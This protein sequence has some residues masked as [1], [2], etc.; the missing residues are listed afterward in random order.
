MTQP[1]CMQWPSLNAWKWPSL[2]AWKRPGQCIE[3]AVS[4]CM[5]MAQSQHRVTTS[6]S[7]LY[8][9]MTS[10]WLVSTLCHSTIILTPLR[11]TS[12]T[13]SHRHRHIRKGSAQWSWCHF[14]AKA[15]QKNHQGQEAR[16]GC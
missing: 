8:V 10:S 15:T 6:W 11:H 2:S 1:Q 16:H 4:R 3:M 13:H 9:T 7:S 14:L 5:E 12:A